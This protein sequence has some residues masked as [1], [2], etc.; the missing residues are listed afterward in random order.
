VVLAGSRSSDRSAYEPTAAVCDV[1]V[2]F[3]SGEDGSSLEL[4]AKLL[5]FALATD[6]F[7]HVAG[8][9]DG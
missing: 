6:C 7:V 3:F 8:E 5:L 4:L 9:E 1:L 2:P